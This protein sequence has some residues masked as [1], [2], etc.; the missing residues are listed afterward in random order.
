[1]ATSEQDRSPKEE[2]KDQSNASKMRNAFQRADSDIKGKIPCDQF[3][4]AAQA[5]GLEPTDDELD[6]LFQHFDKSDENGINFDEFVDM[7]AY[8]EGGSEKDYEAS[9]RKAFK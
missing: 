4:T 6:E 3:S 2:A 5:A 7:M 1:M 9:L 8:L